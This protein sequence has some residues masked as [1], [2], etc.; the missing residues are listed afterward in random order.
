M[1]ISKAHEQF[2]DL[3]EIKFNFPKR[4]VLNRPKKYLGPNWE[5]VI[6]FWLYLDTLS[7][8]QM[9]F[10]DH[11]YYSLSREYR[12]ISRD[13]SFYSSNDTISPCSTTAGDAAYRGA[14]CLSIAVRD[15]THEL[16]GLDKL[17][18][19]KNQL[20]FF[21]LFLNPNPILLQPIS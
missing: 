1:K 17:L 20:V 15:A 8:G 6:N 21:P 5:A 3:L 2:A 19:Q 16:I 10:I 12:R 13:N 18:K 4:D 14:S 11:Q 9:K 7:V